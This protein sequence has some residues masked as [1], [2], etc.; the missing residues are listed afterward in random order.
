[1][2]RTSRAC[3]SGSESFRPSLRTLRPSPRGSY[4]MTVRSGKYDASV[5]KPSAH[6]GWPIMNKGRSPASA[7]SGAW[8]S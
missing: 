5:V 7:A 1:M 8:T 3:T 4:V 6:I 2:S